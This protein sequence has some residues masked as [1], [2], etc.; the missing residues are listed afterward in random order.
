MD[1]GETETRIIQNLVTIRHDL[2]YLTCSEETRGFE[3]SQNE[4]WIRKVT[5]TKI[6]QISFLNRLILMWLG[7]SIID[8]M[9]EDELDGSLNGLEWWI[10]VF[11]WLD[12]W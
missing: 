9:M 1:N 11:W 6:K 8:G 5:F 12:E 4:P 10:I 2:V 3:N 7:L